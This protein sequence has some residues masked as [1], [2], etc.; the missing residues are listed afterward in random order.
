[1]RSGGKADRSVRADAICH[2]LP[3]MGTLGEVLVVAAEG[4]FDHSQRRLR[5]R[6]TGAKHLGLFTQDVPALGGVCGSD[7][8][9]DD[10]EGESCLFGAQDDGGACEAGAPIAAAASVV[11]GGGEQSRRFPVTQDVRSQTEA[12]RESADAHRL[13]LT[14]DRRRVLA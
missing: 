8:G 13:A 5:G 4:T 6:N 7:Q 2:H 14:A 3:E 11:A 10:A 1:M 9:A 12:F